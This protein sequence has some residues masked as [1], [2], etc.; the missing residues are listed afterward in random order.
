MSKMPP[1]AKGG[2][3]E[4]S[5]DLVSLQDATLPGYPRIKLNNTQDT[6]DYVKQDVCCDCLEKNG[7]TSMAVVDALCCKHHYITSPEPAWPEDRRRGRP[8][9]SPSVETRLHLRQAHAKVSAFACLLERLPDGQTN[10][11]AT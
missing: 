5:L 3:L 1:F 11:D 6:T 10:N 7:E 8:R 2:Q 9:A 4:E